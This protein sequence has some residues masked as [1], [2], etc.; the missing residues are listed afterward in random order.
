M[1]DAYELL[2][3]PLS[4]EEAHLVMTRIDANRDGVL[5]YTDI[6]DVFRPKNLALAREF[7]QRMPME[8]QTSQMIS[9]KATKLIKKLF[10]SFVKV[11]NYIQEM[12]QALLGRPNF[13][14]TKAFSV[15]N[16]E[17]EKDGF[18][19]ISIEEVQGILKRHGLI[20][21]PSEVSPLFT[22][23]DKDKDGLVAFNDFKLGIEPVEPPKIIDY[24]RRR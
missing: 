4:S 13:N 19:K 8:L 15:L 22:R 9:F 12:K 5:T 10:T 16:M 14:L 6:C 17:G 7:G 11:E 24:R 18:D 3:V 20:S 23:F 2:G 21:F 1:K